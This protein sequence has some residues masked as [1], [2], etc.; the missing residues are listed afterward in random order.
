M[1]QCKLDSTDLENY[2]SALAELRLL[3]VQEKSETFYRTTEKGLDFL[4]IYHRLRW[5]LWGS[6]ND[7]LLMRLLGQLRKKVHPFYV[8][9]SVVLSSFCFNYASQEADDAD[10]YQEVED[11]S[12]FW[13]L[14]EPFFKGKGGGYDQPSSVGCDE[15]AD[16]GGYVFGYFV[17]FLVLLMFVFAGRKGCEVWVS[18]C[19]SWFLEVFSI[20]FGIL[21][22]L[23]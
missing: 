9:Q 2:L 14:F 10:Y 22:G 5:L 20:G 1:E 6:D 15:D 16:G 4:R 17:H 7:F 13:F 12:P 3:T 23:K 18:I 21:L 19:D 8:S 11:A